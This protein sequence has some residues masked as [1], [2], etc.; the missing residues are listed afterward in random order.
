MT[1]LEKIDI[2]TKVK[3]LKTIIISIY[4]EINEC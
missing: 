3:A 1:F 4:G 2:F